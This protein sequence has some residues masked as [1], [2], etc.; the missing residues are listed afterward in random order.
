MGCVAIGMELID[1]ACHYGAVCGGRITA[2]AS[3]ETSL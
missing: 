2:L 3:F 1:V